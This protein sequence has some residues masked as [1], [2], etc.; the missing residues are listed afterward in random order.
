MVPDFAGGAPLHDARRHVKGGLKF[1]NV[2]RSAT[3][4]VNLAT[5]AD[6]RS[7][8][9]AMPPGMGCDPIFTNVRSDGN[10]L[11]TVQRPDVS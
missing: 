10:V 1:T 4:F 5:D 2:T 9:L 6:P 3:F 11:W 7:A 8:V